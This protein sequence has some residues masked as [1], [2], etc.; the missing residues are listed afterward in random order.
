VRYPGYVECG[1]AHIR[2]LFITRETGG[3]PT[4]DAIQF[5]IHAFYAGNTPKIYTYKLGQTTVDSIAATPYPSPIVDGVSLSFSAGGDYWTYGASTQTVPIGIS[6]IIDGEKIWETGSELIQHTQGAGGNGIG[7]IHINGDCFQIW[8]GS[9]VLEVAKFAGAQRIVNLSF[10]FIIPFYEREGIITYKQETETIS[11]N[12]KEFS[13]PI[14]GGPTKTTIW[15]HQTSGLDLWCSGTGVSGDLVGGA[16]DAYYPNCSVG[17][18]GSESQDAWEWPYGAAGTLVSAESVQ[19]M[20]CPSMSQCDETHGPA[21]HLYWSFIGAAPEAPAAYS[22]GA[23]QDTVSDD[24]TNTCYLKAGPVLF[25]T[26]MPIEDD[27]FLVFNPD[28]IN[29]NND[30]CIAGSPWWMGAW[31]DAF[32]SGCGWLSPSPYA[33]IDDPHKAHVV[34]NLREWSANIESLPS[35][36]H[37]QSGWF[38]CPFPE[39]F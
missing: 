6:P 29:D 11:Y 28:G 22:V 10:S 39:A 13:A 37:W 8:N 35:A 30:S 34:G 19:S 36:T 31:M 12:S 38:G 26:Q 9:A 14:V 16:Y 5:P 4:E 21:R 18:V 15:L 7:F 1:P 17:A 23:D 24:I 2:R 3:R 32:P 33:F 20:I 27:A 25:T